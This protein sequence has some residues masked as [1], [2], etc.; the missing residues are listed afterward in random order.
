[1]IVEYSRKFLKDVQNI[2]DNKLKDYLFDAI[3]VFKNAENLA[4]INNVKKLKGHSEAYRLRIGKYR[5]EFYY[6]GSVIEMERFV[7]R[8][9][10]YKLFP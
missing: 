10:I 4:D 1:M 9:N 5:L 8:E 3:S 2:T 7:K 6:N